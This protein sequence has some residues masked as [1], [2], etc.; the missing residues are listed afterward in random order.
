[1]TLFSSKIPTSKQLSEGKSL[2]QEKFGRWNVS[3]SNDFT[4][5]HTKTIRFIEQACIFEAKI[6][7]RSGLPNKMI[8]TITH[9]DANLAHFVIQIRIDLRTIT[10]LMSLRPIEYCEFSFSIS[11]TK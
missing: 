4:S 7:E 1:M 2:K 11:H 8:K 9:K 10:S 5:K 6:P 3:M